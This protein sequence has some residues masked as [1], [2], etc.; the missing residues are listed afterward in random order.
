MTRFDEFTANLARSGLVPQADLTRARQAVGPVGDD[1]V[2][3]AKA[4]IEQGSLTT[5]QARKV[6]AGMTKG[7]F[8]GG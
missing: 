3:L 7:F 8:L 6:L 5:Y 1:P 2:P 4:L